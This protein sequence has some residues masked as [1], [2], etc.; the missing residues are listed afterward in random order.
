MP[1]VTNDPYKSKIK[2]TW[3]AHA[4]ARQE[5]PRKFV[6]PQGVAAA[7]KSLENRMK[8]MQGVRSG[9]TFQVPE[10][11]SAPIK[12]LQKRMETKQYVGSG[13]AFRVPE[14]ISASV[15]SS[16]NRMKTMQAARSGDIFRVQGPKSVVEI[17]AAAN[18]RMLQNRQAV[19]ARLQGN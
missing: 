17:A 10:Q 11:I 18:A 8:T 7:D 1:I 5:L 9:Q 12:S 4:A 16:E 2:E 15:K 3:E 19:Y 14:Q 6:L 13:N